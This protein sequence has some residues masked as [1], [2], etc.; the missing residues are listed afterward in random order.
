M[1]F[2]YV[3]RGALRDI[4][5]YV[6]RGSPRNVS[7]YVPWC[8]MTEEHNLCSLVPMSTR[9]YVPWDMFFG[10]ISWFFEKY[11]NISYVPQL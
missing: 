3:P 7:S 9:T 2:G 1:F 10:Y 5:G 6:T 8:H 11:K 4:S